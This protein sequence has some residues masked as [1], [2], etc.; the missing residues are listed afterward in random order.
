LSK[1]EKNKP[2]NL[3]SFFCGPQHYFSFFNLARELKSLATPD[4]AGG[5]AMIKFIFT[6]C[7]D[8]SGGRAMIFPDTVR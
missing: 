4:I 6:N 2:K 1:N 3:F 7:D 5:R 8:I